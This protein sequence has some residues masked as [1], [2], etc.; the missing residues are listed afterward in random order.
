MK[1]S[2]TETE[3]KESEIEIDMQKPE[4][5]SDVKKL[6]I[7]PYHGII[8]F[9][10]EIAVF[11]FICVPLQLNFGMLGLALTELILLLLA[12][13]PVRAAKNSIKE[14]FPVKRVRPGQFLA[15]FPFWIASFILNTLIML[16]ITYLF[17]E[18]MS[19]TAEGLSGMFTSVPA[20]LSFLIVAVM[21]AICEEAL[22]R[23][24]IQYSMRGIKSKWALVLIMGLIF[25]IFHLDPIRFLSTALL[26]AILS[27]IM[28]ETKNIIL[29]ALFHLLN[30]T[31]SVLQTFLAG[32]SSAGQ[33]TLSKGGYLSAMGVYLILS[34]GV[35]WLLVLG[36]RLLHSK[37][38]NKEKK[39][40]RKKSILA[41][42][43][44]SPLL[45]A[46]GMAAMV[47][48][49]MALISQ[50]SA[51]ISFTGGF[52]AAETE[53]H[54]VGFA[55]EKSG[56]YHLETDLK[57]QGFV[58]DFRITGAG[59]S[60]PEFQNI[61]EYLSLTCDLELNEGDY[62][63]SLTFIK[64]KAEIEPYL[65][66]MGYTDLLSDQELMDEFLYKAFDH[67]PDNYDYT[68]SFSVVPK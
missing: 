49:G 18:A 11:I 50:P 34:A 51:V 27:Y 16:T 30:N 37:E 8:L 20:A 19:Q 4:I 64:D 46:S 38:Y 5:N 33:M 3:L 14:V 58:S 62:V 66:K 1:K 17:P 24:F 10:I 53:T 26:G 41:A 59:K 65:E 43:I 15:L 22:H 35:P 63:L 44:I 67:S 52:S 48:G 45:F 36:I 28:I 25:G 2:E 54:E 56:L 31:I 47:A 32:E 60:E 13:I 6:E 23:G 40:S 68:F 61:S 55:I 9:V 12:V 42:I 57:A 29:P 7:R 39:A 21:P